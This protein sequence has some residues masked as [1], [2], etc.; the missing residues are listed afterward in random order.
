MRTILIEPY[1]PKWQ[2]N[3]QEIKTFL[4][5]VILN[6]C[7]A[8][9]HVG[10]TAVVGLAA[11]PIID[12]DIVIDS[13]FELIKSKLERLGY[14]H[15]GDQGIKGREVFKYTKTSLATH[16]LYVCQKE[17]VELQKHIAF[18]NHLRQNPATK[19]AYA[20]VKQQAAKMHPHDIDGYLDV[21]G[22]F[23]EKIYR[24]LGL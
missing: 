16:H 9:E 6:C 23:I 4:E 3:F 14:Y 21:K 17:S 1:N 5:K 7:L 12:I 24:K 13:D 22:K 20:R 8:I 10:S 2:T 19:E 15:N 18:R 11:K